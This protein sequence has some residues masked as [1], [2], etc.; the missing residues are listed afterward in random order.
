MTH[1]PEPEETKHLAGSQDVE[2][3]MMFGL[4]WDE[5]IDA[6]GQPVQCSAPSGGAKEGCW[7][8][9]PGFARGTSNVQARAIAGILK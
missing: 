2:S 5:V 3:R 9:A 1:E 7:P 8:S 6:F 4:D